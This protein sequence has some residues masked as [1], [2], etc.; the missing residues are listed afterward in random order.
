MTARKREV[1]G[2]DN[3]TQR[4]CRSVTLTVYSI[5]HFPVN[6]KGF[7]RI[8][9]VFLRI[10]SEGMTSE[11]MGIYKRKKEGP[12]LGAFAVDRSKNLISRRIKATDPL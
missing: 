5:A 2:S 6:V 9:E 3:F 8:F 7:L 12:P 1:F 10:L 4:I 11:E